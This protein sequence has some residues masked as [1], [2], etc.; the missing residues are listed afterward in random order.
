MIK[1]FRKI[2]RDLLNDGK[3]SRYMELTIELLEAEIRP[4]E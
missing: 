2:R 1:F 4:N 3:T